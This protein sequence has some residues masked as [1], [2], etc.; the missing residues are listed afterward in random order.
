VAT[1]PSSR[2][3]S[4]EIL[5]RREQLRAERAGARW[6]LVGGEQWSVYEDEDPYDRRRGPSLVFEG[7]DVV[8]RVKRFP[9]NWR[10]LDGDTL[11]ALSWQR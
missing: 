4:D 6:L 10:E 8:R 1:P 7:A 9:E 5:A 2:K 3:V 11:F